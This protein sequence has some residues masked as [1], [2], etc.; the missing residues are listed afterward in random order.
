[1]SWNKFQ[2]WKIPR[3]HEQALCSHPLTHFKT[4]PHPSSFSTV[5]RQLP[6]NLPEFFH[7]PST[8]VYDEKWRE[9]FSSFLE[10]NKKYQQF[11][12]HFAPLNTQQQT[13]FPLYTYHERLFLLKNPR[14]IEVFYSGGTFYFF[15]SL[16]Q[17]KEKWFI[18]TGGGR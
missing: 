13:F 4:S 10:K 7:A 2:C 12:I 17:N 5:I 3:T 8:P 11:I 16:L 18:K 15:F 6:F 9:S 1:M 14:K